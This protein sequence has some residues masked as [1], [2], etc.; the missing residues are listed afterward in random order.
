VT[1][2][3][4]AAVLAA[5]ALVAAAAPAIEHA[6]DRRDA[7]RVDATVGEAADAVHALARR[8]DPGEHVQIA[9]RRTLA[10]SL[11]ADAT[12]VAEADPPRLVASA[13]NGAETVRR[14]PVRLRVCG[15]R[16]RL[17]G[18]TTFVYVA[19]DGDP[20]VLALRGFIRGD[21]SRAAHACIPGPSPV[22]G[23]PGL[24]V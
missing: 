14:I 20:V 7:A 12:L 11:P 2:R 18:D 1:V 21:G 8:S 15:D 17:R 6:R 23:R 3:V 9:P 13:G 22:V 5:L 24:R 10:I 19:T 16:E 4:V